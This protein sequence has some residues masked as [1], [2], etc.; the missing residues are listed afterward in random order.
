[1]SAHQ[2]EPT[3]RPEPLERRVADELHRRADEIGRRL[4]SELTGEVGVRTADYLPSDELLDHVPR[5]VHGVAE[6]LERPADLT[7]STMA[8]RLAM[9]AGLRREQGYDIEELLIEYERLSELITEAAIETV[10]KYGP[11]ADPVEV[12][13]IFGRLRSVLATI[14]AATVAAYRTE[15]LERQHEL[16]SRLA[17]FGRTLAHELKN[18]LGAAAG[19][20]QMLREEEIADRPVERERFIE[21]IL[22]NLERARALVDDIRR[23]ALSEGR[24]AE[25]E[26]ERA[27]AAID[28]VL[29]E[30]EDEAE[31]RDVEL[32]VV[33]P[34]PPLDVPA[35]AAEIAL[36]NL[37]GNAVKYSDPDK[38]ERWARIR[39]EPT[40][41]TEWVD[42]GGA[43]FEV[44]DN[45]LGIPVSVQPQVFQR[46]FRA[47][48][49]VAEG[50]GLG[51]SIARQVVEAHGGRIGFTSE[52]G[53]GSI[54]RFTL[55]AREAGESE[56]ADESSG[57][58]GGP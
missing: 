53:E 22:N 21:L 43:S 54:F 25:A 50:T 38:P 12:A 2:P 36:I 14:N 18:P 4:V 6:F 57:P 20:T 37:V 32:E 15:E 30:L 23:L 34:V 48:P 8:D 49:E 42:R 26:W 52:P 11:D 7:R 56:E 46:H 1:M 45:G 3:R 35:T 47:H 39:V 40:E 33:E 10:R 29:D 19:G 13:V 55:P 44:S 27:D 9:H 28:I 31:R 41:E 5:V 51:L 58:A 17:E 24:E 16:A